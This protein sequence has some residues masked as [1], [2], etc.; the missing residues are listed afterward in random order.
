VVEVDRLVEVWLTDPEEVANENP[1]K[2]L[3][4]ISPMAIANITTFRTN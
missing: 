1:K 2:V 4:T 3:L